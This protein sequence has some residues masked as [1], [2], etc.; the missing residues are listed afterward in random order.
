MVLI[1]SVALRIVIL[2]AGAG[3][4]LLYRRC[5]NA[6]VYEGLLW[7]LNPSGLAVEFISLVTRPPT[8]LFYIIPSFLS[9]AYAYFLF[10]APLVL[11]FVFAMGFRHYTFFLSSS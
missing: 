6:R 10:P 11:K 3:S 2:V 8:Y 5:F 7:L 9:V 1:I 4:L